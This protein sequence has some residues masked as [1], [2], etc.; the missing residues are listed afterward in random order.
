MR[1]PAPQID[2][3]IFH[4]FT[5]TDIGSTENYGQW[6][7]GAGMY[8]GEADGGASDYGISLLSGTIAIGMGDP[9]VDPN[10]D[11][12]FFSSDVTN[13]SPYVIEYLRVSNTGLLNAYLNATNFASSNCSIGPR[14]GATNPLNIGKGGTND[15]YFVGTIYEILVYNSSLSDS[16]RNAVE[17]YIMWKWGFQNSLPTGHPYKGTNPNRPVPTKL[18]RTVVPYYTRFSPSS[19]AGCMLWL[20]AADSTKMSLSGSIVTSITDKSSNATVFTTSSG[21]T[22]SRNAQN[23]NP[24]ILFTGQTM[25]GTNISPNG[26]SNMNLFLVASQPNA[27]ISCITPYGF[28]GYSENGSWGQVTIG[29]FQDG[30][31]WRYG[32]GVEGNN[33]YIQTPIGS[34]Y[35]IAMANKNGTTETGWVNGTQV[36][37]SS[38]FSSPVSATSSTVGL[39]CGPFNIPS[40]NFAELYV[41]N[42]LLTTAQQQQLESYLAQKWGLSLYLPSS[43]NYKNFPI[44]SPEQLRTSLPSIFKG[45]IPADPLPS[46]YSYPTP[47]RTFLYTTGVYQYY[48][49]PAGITTLGI[50]MW[51][52]GG[53]AQSDGNRCFGG[54]GG[55]VQGNLAVT[56]GEVLTIVVGAG[57]AGDNSGSYTATDANG[58][59]GASVRKPGGG[60]SAIQRVAGVDIV[61]AGGGGGQSDY[62]DYLIGGVA[63]GLQGWVINWV[64]QTAGFADNNGVFSAFWFGGGGSQTMGGQ[65]CVGIAWN[66]ESFSNMPGTK[67]FGGSGT[68][69]V[70]PS[71]W[72]MAG[73][74]GGWYGGASGTGGGGGSSYI[75]GFQ[76]AFKQTFENPSN[77]NGNNEFTGANY[78]SR[79][80]NAS[81]NWG[82]TRIAYNSASSGYPGAVIILPKALTKYDI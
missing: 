53:A 32:T 1:T 79:Y 62:W 75:D 29:I 8:D 71:G 16:Q 72:V 5:T 82:G 12:T 52:G 30:I 19:I 34:N 39:G 10:M 81:S 69:G 26:L 64:P 51:G 61:T 55:C 66:G 65:P 47:L 43:H 50:I 68:A 54:P 67:G 60:R 40:Q 24:V 31:R 42:V 49:V 11:R 46:P 21:P 36:Y 28:L 41:F 4:V 35:A 74:G 57:G 80:Y 9:I 3:S 63:G 15:T 6:W 45:I 25:T 78:T 76:R 33:P 77:M 44:G 2:W 48:T 13:G 59:G 73:G 38:S 58:G 14:Y 37:T 23:G 18:T 7:S 22:L 27:S 56:P 17:G 70:Y 20:D